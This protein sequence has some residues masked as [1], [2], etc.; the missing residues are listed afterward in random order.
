MQQLREGSDFELPVTYKNKEI[1]LTGKLV[2][3]G[4]TYKIFITVDEQ[5]II[6]EPDEERNLRA[7]VENAD[8]RQSIPAAFI[9]AIG[10]SLGKHLR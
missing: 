8:N 3:M 2:Q 10:E 7:I 1:V 6:F 5:E 4:Y 9:Q